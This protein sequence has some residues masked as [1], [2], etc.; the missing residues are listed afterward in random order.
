MRV[1]KVEMTNVKKEYAF[2]EIEAENQ[3][4]AISIA[5][6][7]AVKDFDV[8]EETKAQELSV[9]RRWSFFDLF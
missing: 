3:S 8:H 9:R 5:R 2:V 7:M 1:F 4:E 6:T